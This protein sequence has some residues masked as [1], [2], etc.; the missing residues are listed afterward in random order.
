MKPILT[1]LT[2]FFSV[3]LSFAKV[4]PVNSLIGDDGYRMIMGKVPN[5]SSS[6][7]QRVQSHLLYVAYLLAQKDDRHLSA[8]KKKRRKRILTYLFQYALAGKY[9][10]NFD[11]KTERK[12]CFI[13]AEGTI[14]AVGYLIQETE[15]RDAAVAINETYKYAEV[16]EMD[17]EK[18]ASWAHQNGLT[19]EECAMIQP[20]YG[21]VPNRQR[22]LLFSLGTSYRPTTDFYS[23]FELSLST[24]R[25]FKRRFNSMFALQLTPL[26]NQNWEMALS[27]LKPVYIQNS[28]KAFAG[29]GGEYFNI[30]KR[31]GWNLLPQA[32][33][34]YQKIK[35][36]MCFNTQFTYG[37]HIGLQNQADY[38]PNRNDLSIMI[39]LG[40]NL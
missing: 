4:Q 29:L 7:Q 23:K 10:Q 12:P 16:L 28:W 22:T 9:P 17:V 33:L 26:R 34:A 40:V 24:Q 38:L 35:G 18:I 19:V 31:D 21:W 39:G 6:E 32:G 2:I 11:Y 37:Y 20:T 30:N 8:V 13:D 15:G 36:K 5:G 25:L 14:C 1:V 3:Q 27:Y